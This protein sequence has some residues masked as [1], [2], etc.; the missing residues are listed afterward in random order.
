MYTDHVLIRFAVISCVFGAAAAAC[1]LRKRK[2]VRR[3][4]G[5]ARTLNTVVIYYI[6]SAAGILCSVYSSVQEYISRL[7][8]ENMTGETF[9]FSRWKLFGVIAVLEMICFVAGCA[10]LG[11]RR[12]S[13]DNS[14][15]SAANILL[16][17]TCCVLPRQ[18]GIF[19]K[20]APSLELGEREARGYIMLPLI[21]FGLLLA[22]FALSRLCASYLVKNGFGFGGNLSRARFFLFSLISGALMSAYLS[23]RSCAICLSGCCL[24]LLSGYSA[25]RELF[26][27]DRINGREHTALVIAGALGQLLAALSLV[28]FG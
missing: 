20:L 24:S 16:L 14:T 8:I 17:L 1:A 19:I 28:C 6:L 9:I 10:M 5:E 21:I 27:K 25:L 22:A 11:K 12:R 2:A 15:I 4:D 23:D 13:Q 18:V 7:Y 3:P 26:R